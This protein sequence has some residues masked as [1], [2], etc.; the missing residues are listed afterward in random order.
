[1]LKMLQQ[2]LRVNEAIRIAVSYSS[3]GKREVIVL[4]VS[5]HQLNY[6]YGTPQR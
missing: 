1:M 6:L 4:V 5:Q 3:I 2:H